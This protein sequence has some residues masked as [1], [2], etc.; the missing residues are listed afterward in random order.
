MRRLSG[1]AGP[2]R[3]SCGRRAGVSPPTEL[4]TLAI[5][6]ITI[7]LACAAPLAGSAAGTRPA[8]GIPPASARRQ[9]AVSRAGTRGAGRAESPR[10]G[11][12]TA[13]E[14]SVDQA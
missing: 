13:A 8:T 3:H 14:L 6:G 10:P 11:E 4:V 7:A 12:H 5:G 1:Q 2:T 9:L